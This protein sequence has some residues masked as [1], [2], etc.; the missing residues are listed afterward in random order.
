[1]IGE[2]TIPAILWLGIDSL[3]T[4]FLRPSK[5][6]NRR[7]AGQYPEAPMYSRQTVFASAR[8]I[9]RVWLTAAG[10]LSHGANETGFNVLVERRASRDRRYVP[11]AN[12][13]CVHSNDCA[14]DRARTPGA[15]QH[16]QITLREEEI[17]D[18]SLCTFDVFDREDAFK[19]AAKGTASGPPARAT[20]PGAS[21][22]PRRSASY[23]ARHLSWTR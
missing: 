3:L 8:L 21:A 18:V 16:P 12:R 17:F 5:N 15:M 11:Y 22:D 14:D 19:V 6:R 23:V 13:R 2:A 4:S 20:G 1:M 10:G 7:V 9:R